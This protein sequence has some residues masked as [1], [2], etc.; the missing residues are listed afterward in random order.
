MALHLVGLEEG[1]KISGRG[2]QDFSSQGLG[3]MAWS[4]ARQA[5]LG[6]DSFKRYEGKTMVPATSGRLGQYTTAYVDIG[7]GLLQKLFYAIAETG[8]NQMGMY[9]CCGF[10]ALSWQC[11]HM[12]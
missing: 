3:N 6:T 2:L 8:L 12:S 5:Q 7:E 9:S 11:C 10:S 1:D 4:Y